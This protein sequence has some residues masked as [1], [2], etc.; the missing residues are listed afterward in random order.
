MSKFPGW[1]RIRLPKSWPLLLFGGILIYS[2]GF[3]SGKYGIPPRQYSAGQTGR[4]VDLTNFWQTKR[5]IEDRGVHDVNSQDLITGATKGLVEGIGDP[6]SDYLTKDEMK[7][8]NE[9]LSGTVEGIGVEIGLQDGADGKEVTVIA[10][11][12]DSPAARAGIVAGDRFVS[13]DGQPTAGLSIDAVAKKV[14]GSKG[15]TVK[16]E[17]KS[18]GQSPARSLTLTRETVKSPSIKLEYRNNVAIIMLSRFGDDTKDALDK[19]VTDIQAKHPRGVIL[20]MRSNPGGYLDGAVDVTSVFEKSGL[21]VKERFAHG[22][23]EERSVSNDGRLA[24]LPLVVLVN[25]GS[26]SAA[27]ITAGALRDNRH[28]KLVGEKT[29][30]KGSVQDLISLDQGA[31]LKLTIAEW[32]T[33][34][35]VSISKQGLTPDV[36][37]GSDNPEAQLQAALQQLP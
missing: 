33:P 32:L 30:G 8:L 7:Q 35:G 5:L 31:V 16:I 23:T 24:D 6:Y 15:S 25:K 10:P 21:V 20:D 14:R 36:A 22:K 17:V 3:Y 11:L 28:V 4:A 27:E 26:A 13:V 29:F 19:A 2:V 9:A 37:V 18:A 34:S 12:P 1:F